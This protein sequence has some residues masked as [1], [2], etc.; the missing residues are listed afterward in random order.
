VTVDHVV[1]AVGHVAKT[2]APVTVLHI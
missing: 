1:T 2:S